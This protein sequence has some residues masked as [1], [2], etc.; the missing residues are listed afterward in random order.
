MVDSKLRGNDIYFDNGIWRY[1]EDN[2]ECCNNDKPCI[3]CGKSQ[4]KEGH[5]GCL[6]SLIGV[7]NA[8]CGHRDI[9]ECYV[10]FLDG[11]SIRGNDA[12][13]ILDILKKHKRKV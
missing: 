11:E 4:T 12:K 7:K 9:E 13:I 2:S 8:C 10:Q 5:D 3:N 1:S 6:G